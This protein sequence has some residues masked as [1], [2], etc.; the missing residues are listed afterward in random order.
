MGRLRL[1]GIECNN[2]EIDRQLNQQFIHR[3]ND[4]NKLVEIIMALT[5][6]EENAEVTSDKVLCWVKRIEA[7][8]AQSAIMNSL[9]ET[10]EF[11]KLKIMKATYKDSPRRPSTYV[12]TPAKQI[13]RYCGCSHPL[14]QCLAYGKKC[15]DSSKIGQ[16][17]GFCRSRRARAVNEVEQK[18]V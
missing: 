6:I 4:T 17:R 11:D 14:R 16:F 2:K 13:C 8:R 7:Q 1:S 15:T 5:K 3:L 9:T 18:T 10:K 12:K